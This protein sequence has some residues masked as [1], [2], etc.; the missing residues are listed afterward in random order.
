V[1]ANR[2]A[3]VESSHLSLTLGWPPFAG[4]LGALLALGALATPGRQ[5]WRPR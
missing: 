4:A 2:L 3:G 5:F 1:F